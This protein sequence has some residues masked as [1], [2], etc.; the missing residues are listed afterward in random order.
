MS[1][2]Q[3]KKNICSA[4]L[5]VI[6]L[7]AKCPIRLFLYFDS[8]LQLDKGHKELGQKC[9]EQPKNS[10]PDWTLKVNPKDAKK[11]GPWLLSFGTLCYNH[12]PSHAVIHKCC[13]TPS[14]CNLWG[15]HQQS[16]DVPAYSLLQFSFWR[17]RHVAYGIILQVFFFLFLATFHYLLW[18]LHPL[19]SSY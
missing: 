2:S 17:W 14:L 6:M 3:A 7:I 8:W 15:F 5:F 11:Q 16:S 18:R 12:T 9:F 4:H 1:F 13:L 10:R 19:W